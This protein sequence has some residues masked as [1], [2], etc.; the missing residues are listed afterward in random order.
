MLSF[1]FGVPKDGGEP[2]IVKMRRTAEAIIMGPDLARA[3]SV[4]CEIAHAFSSLS[5][6]FSFFS[7]ASLRL[8]AKK[9]CSVVKELAD[10]GALQ[11]GFG[12]A[13][14]LVNAEGYGNAP[15]AT[16]NA[17]KSVMVSAKG[18]GEYPSSRRDLLRSTSG[19]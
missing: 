19:Q 17:C 12:C 3:R 16:K 11:Q 9:I 6:L 1:F 2:P 13:I 5:F 18:R 10:E 4:V 7:S 8:S 14:L 15:A